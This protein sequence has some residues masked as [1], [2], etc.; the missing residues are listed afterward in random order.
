MQI[1]GIDIGG[2]GI[3][4]A[5]VDLKTEDYL[6]ERFRVPTPQPATPEV[7]ADCVQQLIDHFNWQ[8]P[9]GV[10][11]PTVIVNGKAKA[12]GNLDPSWLNVQIDELFE[13]V[14]VNKSQKKYLFW[15]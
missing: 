15:I 3:K 5:P 11:F 8:G 1:L 9:V 10:G 14:E 2:T 6:A 4:G 7:V 13:K 12:Y